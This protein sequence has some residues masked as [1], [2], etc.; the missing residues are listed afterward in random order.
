MVQT[1]LNC[2]H[3]HYLNNDVHKLILQNASSETVDEA[4]A[5]LKRIIDNHVHEHATAKVLRLFIDAR[6]GVPPLQYFFTEL[7][8]LYGTYEALPTIRAVYVYEDSVVLSLL[9]M[10]FNALRMNASR[11]FIKNGTD[12]EALEWVLSDENP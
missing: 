11:R 9:Q 6:A 1:H 3:Q 5:H 7:R 8:K 10:F 12:V 2:V 4:L